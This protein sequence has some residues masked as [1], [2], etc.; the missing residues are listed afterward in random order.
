MT[1]RFLSIPDLVEAH[2]QRQERNRPTL[3][4]Q[5]PHAEFGESDAEHFREQADTGD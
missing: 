3:D 5:N 2:N 4:E 1:Y